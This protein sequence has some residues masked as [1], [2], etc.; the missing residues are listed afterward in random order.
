MR[1]LLLILTLL[2]VIACMYSCG[3][4]SFEYEGE[5]VNLYS[6]ALNS[7]PGTEGFIQSEIRFDPEINILE[8]DDNGRILFTY[9]EG[10]KIS[11]YSLL[12]MQFSNENEV[13]YYPENSFISSSENVFDD[14]DISQLKADN[15]WNAEIIQTKCNCVPIKTSKDP[16]LLSY[17][18]IKPFYEFV[19]PGDENFSDDRMLKYFLSDDYGRVLIVAEARLTDEWAIMMFLQ[20]GTYDSEN[21]YLILTD[22]YTY[23]KSLHDFLEDV[24]WNAP[25]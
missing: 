12:I 20:D 13:C 21:G 17:E 1:K 14:I 10:N 2:L 23:Q 8:Y 3:N 6:Q 7:I 25:L 16:L 24:S 9:H 22:F 4:Q 19:F 5:Y 11:P 18:Q 15:D